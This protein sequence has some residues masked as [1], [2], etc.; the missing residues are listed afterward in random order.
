MYI[1]NK[2]IV[3]CTEQSI[4]FIEIEIVLTIKQPFE[5]CYLLQLYTLL[6]ATQFE[7][8]H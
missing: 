3:L 7:Q 4:Y 6:L 1:I 2:W 8:S 5:N